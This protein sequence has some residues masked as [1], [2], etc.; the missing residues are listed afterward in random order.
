MCVTGLFESVD[1]SG[2]VTAF[3]ASGLI[4]FLNLTETDQLHALHKELGNTHSPLN[5][6]GLYWVVVNKADFNLTAV[7]RIDGAWRVDHGNPMLGCQAGPRVNQ[8]D[9]AHRQ[10]KGYTR[11]NQSPLA[12]TQS[13]IVRSIEIRAGIATV[14]ALRQRKLLIKALYLNLTKRTYRFYEGMLL[15]HAAQPTLLPPCRTHGL[16]PGGYVYSARWVLPSP[17]D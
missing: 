1:A 5:L 8:A 6:K 12:G 14:G 9:R 2:A 13:D 3:T 11:A 4:E 7:L 17:D 16:G 15:I 10:G